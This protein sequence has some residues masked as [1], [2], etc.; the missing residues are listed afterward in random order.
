MPDA[1]A[2]LMT[3]FAEALERTDPADRAAYLDRACAGDAAI[4]RRVEAL[5]AAR[6]GAGRFLERDATDVSESR[7]AATVET[8]GASAPETCPAPEPASRDD[9]SDGTIAAVPVALPAAPPDGFV[10]GRVIAGRYTLL[11]VMGEGGMGTVYLAEQTAPVR[12][13]VAL[14]LIKVGMASRAVLA[15]F[16]AERQALALMDHPNIA[17]VYDGGTAEAGQPFFVMELV[18]GEP[19]TDYCDGK[20]LPVRA[21]LEL[22]VAVCQAVQHAHQKGIIHRDLKPSNVLVTEVDARPTPKVIDFGVAKATEFPLSELS[23][24][25][26]GAIVGTPTYMS[27]EQAD[28]TSMDIDTRTDIY[29]LGVILYELLAGSPPIDA[30]Q[31]KRGALLEMLRMVR[32]VDPPRP[33]TK[34]STSEAL[35]SIAAMRGIEPEQLKRLLRGDLDWIVMKALEKDRT[36]RYATANGFT[37]D[38]LRHLAYEPVLAAPPSRAYRIRKFVRKHRGAVVAA[39][40]VVVALLAGIA[41]TTWGLIRAERARAAEAERVSERDVALGR[42]RDAERSAEDRAD[43]LNYQLGVSNFLLASA[44]YDDRNIVLATERLDNVPPGQRGWE[45]RYLRR[46]TRGGLFTLYGHTGAVLGV[47]FS[48]DGNRIITGSEDRTARIWDARTGSPLLELKG[49][50]NRV[51]SAAFSP[52][53]ARIVT[54][55]WDQTARVW[56]TRTGSPL[57]ELKGHTSSV[58]SATFSPDGSRIATGSH[59]HTARIWDA[60][61][62][63]ALLELKG[64]TSMVSSA[65]FSCDGARIVTG[66]GDHSARVWDARIGSPLLELKGH[67]EPVTSAAYSP[68]GARI[69]TGSYDRM[70]RVW[71]ARTGSPLLELKGH[72]E[73][74]SSAAFSPDGARIV[75]GSHDHTARVWDARTG[76]PLLE[77][78]GHTHYLWSAAFSPDGAHI[79]TGSHDHTARVWDA[80]TGSPRLEFKGHTS[81]VSSAAFSP[82]GALIVSASGDQMARVWDARTGSLLLE[83]KGHS[84]MVYSAAFSRDGDRIVT[85]SGDQTARVWDARTGSPLLEVKGH[86]GMVYS[87]A[88]SPDGSR[89]VTGSQDPTAR[90]W[91]ARTGSPLLELKGHTRVFSS[92]AFSPDGSR[93]VTGGDD[94]PARIWDART[95]AQVLELR[96]H[97]GVFSS[98]AFSPDGARI[99]TGNG[100]QAAR[101]W[102]A[103]TGSALLELKGHSGMVYSVAFSPDGSR[104]LTGSIDQTARVWDARTGAPLLELKGHTDRVK[105][106]AFSPDG[107]RI[108]TGSN[109]QTV[110]VWD[111]VTVSPRLELRGHTGLV[112]S[113]A[114][115]PDGARIVT[116]SGDQTARVWDTRTGSSLLELKGHTST[117]WSAAF[118]PD[119]ARIVTGSHDQTARVWDAVT[120]SPLLELKGHAS[121]VWSAGFSPDGA[122]IVTGT[123]DAAVRVWDAVRGVRVLEL[124]G[125][126]YRTTNAAFSPDGTRIV[127]HGLVDAGPPTVWDARTGEALKGEPVPPDPWPGPISPDGRWIAHVDGNRVELIPLQPDGEELAYR[128]LLMRPNLARYQENYDAAMESGDEFAARFYLKL[129]PLAERPRIQAELIVKPLFARWLLRDDVL[130]AI[131][132]HPAADPEV[133]AA[134]EELAR[135][136]AESGNAADYNHAGWFLVRERGQPDATYRRGLRLSE[137]ACRLQPGVG[138][139][140]N[141]LGV[142]QYRCGLMAEALA[143]LTRSNELNRQQEPSDLA[144]LALAQHRLG[145]SQPARETLGRLR[146]LMKGSPS[147]DTESQ[148]FL[149]EADAIELDQVFPAD[150][151]AP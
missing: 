101:V 86:S 87:V 14:K 9:T 92:V 149:R 45:W 31:F 114:F 93:I 28:P 104:I 106:V 4:R 151:F 127:T 59:D 12:R 123:N 10:A 21:R 58:T 15:R 141:T 55:S 46:L 57:L 135:T 29:A 95:G 91:D 108:A 124:K 85:G 89:I 116:G 100:D 44:A 24:A 94:Q 128:S 13:L 133:Q 78:K 139:W 66:G 80:R 51:T 56:D 7:S 142:A 110:R 60:V 109:D 131:A 65:A 99:V 68:D 145:L 1:D 40:L 48:P 119:G 26:T 20:R 150:P 47:G 129:F 50:T 33:S 6:E 107:A 138:T 103:R 3:L 82:D 112:T 11:E 61:T 121:M 97:T 146:A 8:T 22:F 5:L 16:D 130:T 41:G 37:A 74:V 62:G 64:H 134:C 39:S 88:F 49:H 83:L 30:T 71:D 63:S 27:P 42:A 148:A 122:R 70:A 111:G 2:G 18:E 96:G 19:I 32:E 84:G 105:S 17:R 118:S 143:T 77:L 35:P 117:V 120:G 43:N 98:V 144:F 126:R 73:T 23:L 81:E 72:A 38:V 25:D 132:A 113:V 140:L 115:S 54:G 75:T 36:R 79:V 137:A 76:S 53:G 69:V 136:W 67:T 125:Q 102:D 34:V 52:D 147:G 90:V